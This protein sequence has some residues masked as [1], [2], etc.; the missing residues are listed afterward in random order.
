M[1]LSWP[2]CEDGAQ[3]SGG[4]QHFTGRSQGG[5]DVS[6]KSSLVRADDEYMEN[7][8]QA[9]RNNQS[10]GS[11]R[12]TRG[13]VANPSTRW[14]VG[15]LSSAVTGDVMPWKNTVY[16]MFHILPSF[17]ITDSVPFPQG[18]GLD[19][20]VLRSLGKGRGCGLT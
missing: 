2:V 1:A 7:Y 6:L 20:G 8:N 12:R 5:R 4:G 15:P 14:H 13:T 3:G 17:T 16:I 11:P 18:Q 19:I 9:K 10:S